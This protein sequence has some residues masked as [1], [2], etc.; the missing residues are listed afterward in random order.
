MQAPTPQMP[1]VQL[2]EQHCIAFAQSWPLGVH[3]APT[4]QVPLAH[5][6]EQHSGSLA[7]GMS[8]AVHAAAPHVPPVHTWP[9]QSAFA[10]HASPLGA[11]VGPPLLL[12][13]LLAP[14][15]PPLDVLTPPPPLD[16]L[17]VVWIVVDPPAPPAALVE[18]PSTSGYSCVGAVQPTPAVNMTPSSAGIEAKITMSREGMGFSEA[19]SRL[20]GSIWRAHEGS[21]GA[22]ERVI[23]WAGSRAACPTTGASGHPACRSTAR[24]AR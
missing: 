9:Q 21:R 18:P 12:L 15:P 7:H 10:E 17:D 5:V 2:C 13:L 11:H 24:G 16:A 1:L 4:V 20:R 8:L 14:P 3:V 6:P 23:G 19:R 22:G